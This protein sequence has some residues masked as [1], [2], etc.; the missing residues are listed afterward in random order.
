MSSLTYYVNNLER[1]I[2]LAHPIAMIIYNFFAYF[3]LGICVAS[4]E[5]KIAKRKLP[6][7]LA[8]ILF[9]NYY[10]KYTYN[11]IVSQSI[12]VSVAVFFLFLSILDENINRNILFSIQ[13]EVY[14]VI[15]VVHVLFVIRVEYLKRKKIIK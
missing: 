14:V 6:I 11:T 1:D 7:F 5:K 3:L 9:L 2:T 15:F 13:S 10:P 8:V 12:V 4:R